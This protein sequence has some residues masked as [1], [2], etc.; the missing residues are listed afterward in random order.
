VLYIFL[1]SFSKLIINFAKIKNYYTMDDFL[2]PF[3]PISYHYYEI[4]MAADSDVVFDAWTGAVLRNNLLYAADK[5]RVEEQACSLRELIDKLPLNISHPLY[6]EL[7]DGF[8][9]GFVLSG[10][11]HFNL[12]SE[13]VHIRKN[14]VFTF[15]LTLIGNF[16]DYRFY[17]FEAIRQMCK[18]GIGK[19][20]T[21]FALLD[22][23]EKHSACLAD[24]FEPEWEG[25]SSE[26][27]VR[28]ETP[29]I[30]FRLKSKKNTQLSYQDKSNRFPGFYQ[31]VRSAFFR[32][33]KLYAIYAG[34]DKYESVLFN[35]E[36]VET[37][38]KKA[39]YPL[40]KSANIQYV[41]LRNTQKKGKL[42]EMPLSGYVGEQVYIGNCREYLPLLKF[43]SELGVGNEVVYGMGRYEI[44]CK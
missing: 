36:A 37:Y 12:E 21:P 42:N 10:F 14:E 31:L 7:K 13:T 44:D 30:L 40:L 3:Y 34:P 9:K 19:P 1:R 28:H 41:T 39:G 4:C 25:S 18:R 5:V 16:N 26:F 33:Q 29:V 38:L 24:F 2:T 15:S 35:E 6:N 22:I 20:L 32:M 27:T 8:P 43:M 17:F 11:S 23:S